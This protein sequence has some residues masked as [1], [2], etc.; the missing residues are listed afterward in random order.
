MTGSTVLDINVT[1]SKLH[2][3]ATNNPAFQVKDPT[4]DS[5]T[6]IIVRLTESLD[7]ICR[8]WDT[9]QLTAR[10]VVPT[11]PAS[12]HIVFGTRIYLP[13]LNIRICFPYCRIR[14]YF[15]YCKLGSV[16][17][18]LSPLLSPVLLFQSSSDP[19]DRL[20]LHI[21]NFDLP[22][23]PIAQHGGSECDLTLPHVTIDTG[24]SNPHVYVI[25]VL[26]CRYLV[27]HCYHYL[28]YQSVC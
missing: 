26:T 9:R 8:Y 12:F 19:L 21:V 13:Y 1:D 11:F 5:T 10:L 25:N 3:I 24:S 2:V 20:V 23:Q 28:F 14:L 7:A 18:P 22:A 6:Y 15:P 4:S 17:P 16:S 27:S